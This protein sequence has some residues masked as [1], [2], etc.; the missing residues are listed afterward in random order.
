VWKL[1]AEKKL[2]TVKVYNRTLVIVSSL[3]ALLAPAS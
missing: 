1:I 2:E 3:R